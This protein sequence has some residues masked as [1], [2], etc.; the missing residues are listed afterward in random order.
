MI[1]YGASA[2]GKVFMCHSGAIANNMFKINLKP[3][4]LP[5]YVM[6]YLSQNSIYTLLNSSG[7]RS[8]M[9]AINFKLVGSIHI[10]I[11][12]YSEQQRIISILDKFE[13]LVNDL[14]QGLPAEIAAVQEQYEYYRNKLLSFPQIIEA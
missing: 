14:Q 5:K 3:E 13:I 12:P 7:G 2:A 4:I 1:R 8:T 9:P 11:P 6:Y 10:S